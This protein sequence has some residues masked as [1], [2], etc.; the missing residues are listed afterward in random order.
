LPQRDYSNYDDFFAA[1]RKSRDFDVKQYVAEHLNG[2]NNRVVRGEFTKSSDA[3]YPDEVAIWTFEALDRLKKEL[4]LELSNE[5]QYY[6]L[7]I[8]FRLIPEFNRNM[9]TVLE[10]LSTVERV[11]GPNRI[12]GYPNLL[13]EWAADWK[14]NELESVSIKTRNGEP[15]AF[16]NKI[17]IRR[18]TIPP[19]RYEMTFL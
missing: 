18:D 19:A 15:V 8:Y 16:L 2:L 7:R 5:S 14:N 12:K 1:T 4:P 17:V 3:N 13:V 9:K 11:D 10:A 6:P